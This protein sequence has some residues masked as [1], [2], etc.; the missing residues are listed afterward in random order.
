MIKGATGLTGWN[1]ESHT[2]GMEALRS[3]TSTGDC[4]HAAL[5]NFFQPGALNPQ[6]PCDGG[7]DN[8]KRRCVAGSAGLANEG[9]CAARK[10]AACEVSKLGDTKQDISR[11]TAS[12]GSA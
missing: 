10:P 2:R 12:A 3:Y 1:L 11:G 4:R 6:G 8:C 5:V 9:L 7:C